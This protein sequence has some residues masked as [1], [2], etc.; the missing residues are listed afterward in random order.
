MALNDRAYTR[1]ITWLKI[2]LPLLALA[3]LSTLFLL[4]RE[5]DPATRIPF[6]DRAIVD[7]AE[8]QQVTEPF[9]SGTTSDGALLSIAADAARPDAEN[10]DRA[11]AED[12]RA[13][14]LLTDGG[15][16]LLR[17]AGATLDQ[18]DAS[19]MLRDDVQIQS[20][21]GYD[22]RTSALRAA[23]DRIDVES[24]APVTATG[25]AGRLTAGRMKITSQGG[26]DD[27]QLHFTDGVKLV[28]DPAE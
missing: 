25:P 26:T 11:I 22:I 19:A 20:S 8:R 17:A 18:S 27:V 13:R 4:S 28:Y 15:E 3:L 16:I 24:L 9:F 7:R 21:T 1:V 14:I 2:L 10:A 23:L 12:V 6:S 5:R